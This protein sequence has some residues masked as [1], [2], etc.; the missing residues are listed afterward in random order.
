M[1]GRCHLSALLTLLCAVTPPVL[2]GVSWQCK[3]FANGTWRC[4]PAALATPPAPAT[5]PGP[6]SSTGATPPPASGTPGPAPSTAPAPPAASADLQPEPAQPAAATPPVPPSTPAGSSGAARPGRATEPP[7]EDRWAQCPPLEQAQEAGAPTTGK[8]VIDLRADFANAT[9]DRVFTL[10]GDAIARYGKQRLQASQIVYHQLTGTVEATGG[11]HFSGPQ[12]VV[13]G[14]SALLQTREQRGTLTD[15]TYTLPV[16]HAHGGASELTVD[17]L[18]RQHLENASYTTCPSGREDWKLTAARVDLDHE[19]GNG[20]AHNAKITFRNIPIAYT[21]YISFPLN[22]QRKT[23]LL[24]PR[25]GTSGQT[26][27]DVSLPWYWNIAPNRD[28]TLTPRLMTD[29]GTQLAAEFRYLNPGSS[30]ALRVEYLPTDKAYNDQ[31]RSLVRLQHTGNP[32]PRLATR[33]TATEVSDR[34]YFDNLGNDLVQTSQTSLERTAGATYHGQDWVLG[35]V[36]QDF[37]NLDPTLTRSELPYR[38]LPQIRFD[39]TP[40]RHLLGLK[41][42]TEAELNYF[43]HPDNTVVYGTRFDITPR[44]SL[45]VQRAGWYINP[46]VGVR[47]TAYA[48]ENTVPGAP[49]HPTRTTSITTLDAGSFFERNG[50]WRSYHFVQ[51]LEPRLFYLYVPERNQ[52]DLPVFDTGNYD[53]NFWT[54]FRDNRFNGPDRMGDANQLALA[55]TSRLL[56][57]DSGVQMLSASFGSLLYFRDRTVTLPGS[58]VDLATSSDL[59]GELNLALTR[60]W[61]ARAEVLWNPH[62]SSTERSNYRLQY[63]LGPRQLINAGYR[64]RQDAQEQTDV[65]FLWPMGRSWHAVGRWYYDLGSNKTIEGLLG[66]GYESCCWGV[67]LLGRSYVNST[68]IGHTN[69]VFL[70]LELKG[71]GKLGSS[72]DDALERGI[73]GYHANQ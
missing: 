60:Y 37:Q 23:G 73:L 27:L 20:V 34:D 7:E 35:M 24:F 52:N 30:G 8:D 29:R 21:P 41:A 67:Q 55:V 31:D 62:L 70:Q 4:T 13:T 32:T 2:A 59:I 3:S 1:K 12:L 18:Y 28:L 64:Y 51:T 16:Q 50:H 56:E 25:V 44:L 46:A 68:G 15:V 48:L 36:A 9:R 11:I 53:F 6:P 43:T 63:R 22:D 54:L 49:S 45:P 66:I 47:Y 14:A 5:A 17:G 65:S 57:P 33:I 61:S 40:A 42:T 39:Y 26:G 72:V 19:T 58:T 10:S 69:S 38:Q 71:L